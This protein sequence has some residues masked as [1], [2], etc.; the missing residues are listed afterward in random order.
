MDLTYSVRVLT[1]EGGVFR[2]SDFSAKQYADTFYFRLVSGDGDERIY[3][4]VLSY[5][6]TTYCEFIINNGIEENIDGL[7][8]AVCDY[9]AAARAYFGYEIN[10]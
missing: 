4:R 9:S 2:F 10:G 7:C 8:R 6:V 5:S 3:S 1:A